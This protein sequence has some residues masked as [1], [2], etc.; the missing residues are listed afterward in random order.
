MWMLKRRVLWSTNNIC[1]HSFY[2]ILITCYA[3]G[4]PKPSDDVSTLLN[5]VSTLL[6]DMSTLLYDVSTLLYD[7]ST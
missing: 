3:Y 4:T 1:L 6:N 5:Y 7:M 2:Q